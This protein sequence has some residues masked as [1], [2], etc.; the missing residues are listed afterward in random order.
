MDWGQ[1]LMGCEGDPNNPSIGD[2]SK[3]IRT[4]MEIEKAS[5]FGGAKRLLKWLLVGIQRKYP[6]IQRRDYHTDMRV[7]NTFLRDWLF[8]PAKRQKLS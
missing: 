8:C 3:V 4:G 2:I 5:G 6:F 7:A 1:P